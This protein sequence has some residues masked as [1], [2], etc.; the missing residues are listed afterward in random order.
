MSEREKQVKRAQLHRQAENERQRTLSELE[1]LYR[2]SKVRLG[3]GLQWMGLRGGEMGLEG[4]LGSGGVGGGQLGTPRN[5]LTSK[6]GGRW[7]SG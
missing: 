2:A 4:R 3:E 5:G 7:M 6:V 1:Q